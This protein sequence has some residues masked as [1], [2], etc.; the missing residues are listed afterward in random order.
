MHKRGADKAKPKL[1]QANQPFTPIVHKAVNPVETP[2]EPLRLDDLAT[3]K[4]GGDHAPH[5][6]AV[7]TPEHP[8]EIPNDWKDLRRVLVM[9]LDIVDRMASRKLVSVETQTIQKA[10]DFAPG[11]IPPETARKFGE[12]T[13]ASFGE[14]DSSETSPVG[15]QNIPAKKVA[16]QHQVGRVRVETAVAGRHSIENI[17]LGNP[18]RD[19]NSTATED[20]ASKGS[21]GDG[22]LQKRLHEMSL[23]LK[24]LETQL[25]DLN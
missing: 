14:S 24:R 1:A 7:L 2:Y 13:E 8:P 20:S 17:P 11:Q 9:A 21:G 15:K 4:S 25:D 23:L 19:G 12:I 16:I 10:V 3:P 18:P 22:N 5:H 6:H